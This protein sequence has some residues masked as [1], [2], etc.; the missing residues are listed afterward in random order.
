MRLHRQ[1][2]H[3]MGFGTFVSSKYLKSLRQ[4]L[5]FL[6]VARDD[7]PIVD[8]F[9]YIGKAGILIGLIIFFSARDEWP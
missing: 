7:E 2:H 8:L 5:Y 9:S 1:E 6:F 4:Q 3:I